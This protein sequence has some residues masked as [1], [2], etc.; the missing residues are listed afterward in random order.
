MNRLKW[1]IYGALPVLA[2]VLTG[3]GF[4]LYAFRAPLT[5]PYDIK[6]LGLGTR[7]TVVIAMSTSC[8]SCV[9]SMEFYKSL[10]ALPEMDGKAGRVIGVAMDGVWPMHEI[11]AAE[12]FKPH[13]LTSGPYMTQSL[14]GVSQ[15]GTILLLDA[16]G[17]QR[18]R[19]VGRLTDAEQEEL[20]AALK[21]V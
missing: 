7:A 18:G 21:G 2:A 3:A 19:W 4:S 1:P 5:E 6:E 11:I 8:Q 16:D 20:I 14:P 15:P 13:R 10:L 12:G 9:E 17:R